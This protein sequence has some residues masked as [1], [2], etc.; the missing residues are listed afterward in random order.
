M[1]K[2]IF[3]CF[4]SLIFCGIIAYL[5]P[6]DTK[7]LN[8]ESKR[9]S[10][11]S[12]QKRDPFDLKYQLSAW[13]GH[14]YEVVKYVKARMH[15]PKSFEHVETKPYSYRDGRLILMKYR[16]TNLFNAVLTYH[17]LLKVNMKGEVLEDVT[18]LAK[19]LLPDYERE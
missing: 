15:D 8:K 5:I 4:V 17:I 13:D 18:H 2:L 12:V 16:G 7:D 11:Q 14:H 3:W 9:A 19:Q 10:K 6:N 1:K